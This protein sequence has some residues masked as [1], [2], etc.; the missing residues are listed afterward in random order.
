M[1]PTRVKNPE[2]CEYFTSKRV[3]EIGENL[4]ARFNGRSTRPR[5]RADGVLA[6]YLMPGVVNHLPML[7]LGAEHHNV[8]VFFSPDTVPGWPVE[9]VSTV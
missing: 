6:T 2:P 5:L 9:Q 8:S 7:T 3:K 4:I 1:G